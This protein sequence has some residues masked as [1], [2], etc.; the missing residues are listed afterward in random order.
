MSA[1]CPLGLKAG[2]DEKVPPI[3]SA[4]MIVGGVGLMAAGK[5]KG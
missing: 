1:G 5:R 3:M 2:I 4:V